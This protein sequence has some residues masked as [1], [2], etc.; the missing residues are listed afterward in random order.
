MRWESVNKI[1]YRR[2]EKC[3]QCGKQATLMISATRVKPVILEGFDEHLDT[4]ITGPA[5]KKRVMREKNLEE[6]G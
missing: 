2:L 4:H 5:H 3:P 6:K 1:Q